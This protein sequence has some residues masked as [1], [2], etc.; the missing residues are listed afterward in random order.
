MAIRSHNTVEGH[1]LWYDFLLVNI[2]WVGLF[3]K[4]A[5]KEPLNLQSQSLA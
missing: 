2:S 3:N 5:W 1:Q 4:I